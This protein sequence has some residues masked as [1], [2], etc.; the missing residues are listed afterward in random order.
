MALIKRKSLLS[1]ITLQSLGIFS[2]SDMP[3]APLSGA[4]YR[5]IKYEIGTEEIKSTKNH[6]VS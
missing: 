1:L 2:R 6:P 5:Y 3:D 4:P